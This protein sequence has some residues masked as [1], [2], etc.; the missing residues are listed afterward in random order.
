MSGIV[1]LERK[2]QITQPTGRKD[3]P[4]FIGIKMVMKC[5]IGKA[6]RSFLIKSTQSILQKESCPLF[7][8]EGEKDVECLI[9]NKVPATTIPGGSNGWNIAK[10]TYFPDH[11]RGIEVV[12]IPDNDEPEKIAEST[13]RALKQAASQV[14]ILR[15][16]DLKPGGDVSDWFANGG[17]T[18]ILED[19]LVDAKPYVAPDLSFDVYDNLDEKDRRDTEVD[20]YETFESTITTTKS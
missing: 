11:F 18:E 5:G 8:V 19:I 15:L 10:I 7:F 12:I 2:I 4:G 9:E 1:L 20:L 3:S 14:V 17:S 6:L 16:P 13:A